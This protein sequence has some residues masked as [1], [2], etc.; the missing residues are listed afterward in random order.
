MYIIVTTGLHG[1]HGERV[2]D[3]TVQGRG[4][5]R[6]FVFDEQSADFNR[7]ILYACG[8]CVVR[9]TGGYVVITM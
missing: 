6:R 8:A 9:S 7:Y 1:L 3:L 2:R 5:L 4:R